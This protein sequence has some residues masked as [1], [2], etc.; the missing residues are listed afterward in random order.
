MVVPEPEPIP[1]PDAPDVPAWDCAGALQARI[2]RGPCGPGRPEG[3]PRQKIPEPAQPRLRTGVGPVFGLL[4]A[5]LFS[6]AQYGPATV[7]LNT[8]LRWPELVDPYEIH[9]LQYSSHYGVIFGCWL[10]GFALHRGRRKF[11]L[12]AELVG[13]AGCIIARGGSFLEVALGR[14][15]YG[16]AAGVFFCV[17]PKML[18]EMAPS[19]DFARSYVAL[20][21]ASYSVLKTLCELFMVWDWWELFVLCPVPFMFIAGCI[22]LCHLRPGTDTI[23]WHCWQGE[24]GREAC[25][26]L[27]RKVA[28]GGSSA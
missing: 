27:L 10:G 9:G 26:A 15:L 17:V 2:A 23:A 28:P 6:V 7:Q 5:C 20:L 21:T 24:K 1:E 18:H 12:A 8:A 25:I 16:A 13:I 19:E 3:E 14:F 22:L 11:V 4:L